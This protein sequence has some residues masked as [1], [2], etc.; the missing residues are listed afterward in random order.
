TFK[1]KPLDDGL[2]EFEPLDGQGS[3]SGATITNGEYRIPRNLG[4]M[5]G[6]YRVTIIGGDGTSG[7]GSAEPVAPGPDLP[8]GVTPAK[9]RIPPEYNDPSTIIREVKKGETNKFDFNI[10]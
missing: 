5:P 10:S 3:K 4:L 9:E 7:R 2:I 6:R 1:G 8:P